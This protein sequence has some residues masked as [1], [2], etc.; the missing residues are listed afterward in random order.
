MWV[1]KEKVMQVLAAHMSLLFF[2]L[3]VMADGSQSW[4]RAVLIMM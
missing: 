4:I 1:E 3:R 2:I